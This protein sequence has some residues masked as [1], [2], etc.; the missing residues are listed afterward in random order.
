MQRILVVDGDDMS[1]DILTRRLKKA[2]YSVG[3]A[4]NGEE[5]VLEA[6]RTIPD[7]ILM[8]L[9]LPIMD[10]WQSMD[11]L[12]KIETTKSIPVIAL[13]GL[14]DPKAREAAF[15]SGC[16]SFEAKPINFQRLLGKIQGALQ[17]E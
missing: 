4:T 2:D 15:A 3:V 9:D 14:R 12:K 7:I 10:G 8:D 13:S 16:V 17:A 1:V 11:L 5:A 6:D